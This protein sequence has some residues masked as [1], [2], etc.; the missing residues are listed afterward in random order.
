MD[1]DRNDGGF[2]HFVPHRIGR[3]L[4]LPLRRVG[5]EARA[6][7]QHSPAIEGR[8]FSVKLRDER[9]GRSDP[10]E[11]L[12]LSSTVGEPGPSARHCP[13]MAAAQATIRGE[14]RTQSGV[15]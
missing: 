9:H 2:W 12:S 15:R 5:E 8:S 4:P 14:K 11:F 1:W 7:E 10:E 6:I 13:Y 3:E